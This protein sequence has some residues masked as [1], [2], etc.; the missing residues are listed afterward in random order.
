MTAETMAPNP[1]K[2]NPAKPIS[3]KPQIIFC[4]VGMVLCAGLFFRNVM[5][6]SV[7]KPLPKMGKIADFNFLERGGKRLQ[8]KDL[9]GQVLNW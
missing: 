5:R 6:R 9:L 3:L 1:A 4:A 7:A 8:L 2:P